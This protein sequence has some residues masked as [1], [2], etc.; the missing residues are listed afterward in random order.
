MQTNSPSSN[1][2]LN[3]EAP[4]SASAKSQAAA[5]TRGFDFCA[6]CRLNHDQGSRHKYFPNHKKALR[7]YLSRFASKLADVRF[8]LK[9][10]T[11]LRPEHAPRNRFWCVFC[12]SDIQ[13]E[14][15]PFACYNAITHLAGAEHLK[16]MKHFMWKHG[17]SMDRMDEFRILDADFTKWKK[18]CAFL[19]KDLPA[20]SEGT[21][22]RACKPLNNIQIKQGHDFVDDFVNNVNSPLNLNY[23]NSVMPLQCTT[24]EHEISDAKSTGAANDCQLYNNG[25]A[26]MSVG[27]RLPHSLRGTAS[28]SYPLPKGFQTKNGV[29]SRLANNGSLTNVDGNGGLQALENLTQ[30]SPS[31]GHINGNVHSGGP[32]PWLDASE[33]SQMDSYANTSSSI[34]VPLSSSCKKSK[35]LNPKRVGAAWAEKRK[36]ELEMER[37]GEAVK[38]IEDT[39]WLPNFGR[40]W[41]SG[42]RK[43]SRKEFEKEKR[44][45]SD[46]EIQPV[47]PVDIQP[48]VCKRMRGGG[49]PSLDASS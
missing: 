7:D 19:E 3:S 23:S 25:P 35:K 37:R 36:M 1:P 30:I 49:D 13:E 8:F 16:N 22:G 2:N 47:T 6:V 32:P 39:N 33:C 20:Y 26:V 11:V 44:K 5:S 29:A 43:E 28:S 48:Y 12:D 27:N 9:N 18:N 14:D 34:A 41:Q 4:K 38:S 40:V 42:S 31:C 46:V 45:F 15:S 10:P 24:N 21:R 17:G